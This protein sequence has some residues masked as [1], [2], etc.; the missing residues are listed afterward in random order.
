MENQ[1]LNGL[2]WKSKYFK[3]EKASR[4]ESRLALA[5]IPR[6]NEREQEVFFI[7]KYTDN[8]YKIVKMRSVKEKGQECESLDKQAI[9]EEKEYWQKVEDIFSGQEETEK[10]M[11]DGKLDE[12]VSRSKRVLFE[13]A[14]CNEWEY[15]VTLTLDQEK[16][17]SRY[18]LASIAKKMQKLVTK[19]NR[20]IRDGK[21]TRTKKMEYVLIPEKHDKGGWHFH[22]FMRGFEESDIRY[23]KHHYQEWV[24][25]REEMGF[26]NMQ[27]IRN[28]EACAKYATKYITKDLR[29]SINGK[30]EHVYYASHGLKRAETIYRGHGQY[31]GEYDFTHKEGYCALATVTKQELHDNFVKEW[32]ECIE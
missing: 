31:F 13:Y 10:P 32:G 3:G 17:E 18:D 25:W 20:P 24:Q 29:R 27:K 19:I 22:G 8:M 1:A 21:G 7:K 4:R 11:T 9:R 2:K 30:G 14:M 23:N 12:S 28:P 16:V 5:K 15:F 26:M 6:K